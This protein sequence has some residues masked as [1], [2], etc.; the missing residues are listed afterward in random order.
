MRIFAR[1]LDRSAGIA[2]AECDMRAMTQHVVEAERG[3]HVVAVLPKPAAGFSGFIEQL[4]DHLLRT[5]VGGRRWR[6]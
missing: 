4:G 5:A 1:C 3:P 6:L 2:L